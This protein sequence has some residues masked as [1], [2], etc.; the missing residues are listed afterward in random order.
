TPHHRLVAI[1]C[2]IDRMR[3]RGPGTRIG[4]GA[5]SMRADEPYHF[6]AI[7][8]RLDGFEDAWVDPEAPV[9]ISQ[10]VDPEVRLPITHESDSAH[11]PERPARDSR[12]VWTLA[13]L[14]VVLLT[15]S[16]LWPTMLQA[17][18]RARSDELRTQVLSLQE[19]LLRTEMRLEH[20]GRA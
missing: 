1:P 6:V 9:P 13:I 7:D 18:Y 17:R 20:A 8:R 19:R 3:C 16:V 4:G 5:L 2:L 12:A 14:C 15:W 11:S 10:E